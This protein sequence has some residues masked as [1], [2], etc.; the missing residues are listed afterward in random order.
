MCIR[1]RSVNDGALA[2][3]RA[4]RGAARE[5]DDERGR[6]RGNAGM[7]AKKNAKKWTPPPWDERPLRKSDKKSQGVTNPYASKPT[8]A[9]VTKR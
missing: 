8:K 6:A 3:T 9:R 1:D 4:A 2:E 5:A 7:P